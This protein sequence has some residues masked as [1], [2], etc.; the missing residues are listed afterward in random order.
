MSFIGASPGYYRRVEWRDKV[1]EA[2]RDAIDDGCADIGGGVATAEI[3]DRIPDR[4]RS[5]VAERVCWL[6]DEGVLERRSGIAYD[7]M[8][9]RASY[10][11]AEGGEE[12]EVSL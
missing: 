4:D 6:T 5:V 2:I 12:M 1:C 9:P 11:I 8:R 7:L 10:V 3:S